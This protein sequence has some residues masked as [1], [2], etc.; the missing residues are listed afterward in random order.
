[1]Y[2]R[3]FD[4]DTIKEFMIGLSLTNHDLLTKILLNKKIS[5]DNMLK[6]GLIVKNNYGYNDI[7]NNRLMFPIWDITGKVVGF[8]GRV[9][10]GEDTSKFSKYINT[11]E[12]PIF[13]KGELLYNYHKAKDSCRQKNVVI[14]MEGQLDLIR[15]YSVG[16]KNVVATMGTAFT[17]EHAVL[18]KRLARDVIICFDGDSAG[19]KA[20]IACGNELLNVGVT[21][22][23]VR[24]EDKLDPDE[25]IKK[26]GKEKFILK[27]D[28]PI[29]FMDFKL[30]FYKNGKDLCWKNQRCL[31]T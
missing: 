4:D 25:Y 26:Y 7:Y 18:V 12:T 9:F 16:V 21:P 11:K 2:D 10:N 22:K 19:E 6:S 30:S 31:Q 13:K 20:S 23:I 3:G 24:L 27:L 1:M 5:Y 15:A 14:L 17:K 28:N 29:N 8:S